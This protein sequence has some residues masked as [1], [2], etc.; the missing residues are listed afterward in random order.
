MK[1]SVHKWGETQ[2]TSSKFYNQIVKKTSIAWPNSTHSLLKSSLC[3]HPWHESSC[4]QRNTVV[5]MSPAL[6]DNFLPSIPVTLGRLS[7]ASGQVR[8]GTAL[9]RLKLLLPGQV[10]L[11]QILCW[12][13][14]VSQNIQK[15]LCGH[16]VQLDPR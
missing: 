5:Q 3:W 4:F 8:L 13:L 7:A 15:V 1:I 11:G 12:R 14:G 2:E 16:S 9:Y 6:K 10:S